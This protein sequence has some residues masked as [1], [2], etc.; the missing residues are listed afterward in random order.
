SYTDGNRT[1]FPHEYIFD[2]NEIKCFNQL[3]IFTRTSGDTVGVIGDYEIYVADELEGDQTQWRKVT[4][5]TTRYHNGQAPKDLSISLPSTE[6]RYIKVR[7]LNNRDDY[8]LTILAEV[9]VSNKTTVNQLIAQD[10]SYIQ[11]IGNWVKDINGA[12]V[13]GGTYNS[14][15]GSFNYAIN[16]SETNIYVSQDTEVE[17]SIDGGPW[18][19]YSLQGSLRE[20]SITLNMDSDGVHTIEVRTIGQQINLNMIS[21]DG[22]FIKED[23]PDRTQ[24]PQMTGVDNVEIGIGE[25]DNFDRLKDIVVIDDRDQDLT[26]TV[27]GEIKKPTPGTN[28]ISVLTYQVT[29]SD[30]NT[31]VIEREIMVTNQLPTLEGASITIQEGEE[32]ELVTDSRL[33]LMAT[34]YEDGDLVS[35]INVIDLDG[36]NPKSP[37]VGEYSITYEVLDSDGNQATLT[38]NISVIEKGHPIINGVEDLTIMSGQAFDP[39]TGI[40]AIDSV[41]QEPLQIEVIGQID[42]YQIGEQ[43]LT[44]QIMTLDGEAIE[45]QR[46]ITVTYLSE[47]S[48]D[49]EVAQC[50]IPHTELQFQ[51]LIEEI[52]QYDTNAML[53][54][55]KEEVDH[56]IYRIKITAMESTNSTQ[57]EYLIDIKVAKDINFEPVLPEVKPETPSEPALPEVKPETPSEPALPEVKPEQPSEPEHPEVKPEVPSEPEKPEVKPGTPSEPEQPSE[58][59]HPEV[60]PEVPSEPADPE[61]KPEQPSEPK[62]PEV[63]PSNDMDTRT[64]KIVP[65]TGHV[66]GMSLLSGLFMILVSLFPWKKRQ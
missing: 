34:D 56:F 33:G 41:S 59:A 54:E 61:V 27:I 55:R 40:Y 38:L 52:K 10:S 63:K 65:V 48:T 45:I 7:A 13:N 60:K 4:E 39:M 26:P 18:I 22:T 58:P 30:G 31:T 15:N 36:F 64:D 57:T 66:R 37:C 2:L 23:A 62:H 35:K 17:V 47:E 9:K 6:A 29:D 32:I 43:T 20:P 28:E 49:L 11:Y 44:Y 46:T 50:F 25:V 51:Q 16:G 14:S 12:F 42:L 8:N 1:P 19:K 3:E 21:T 24:G 5:D 53:I